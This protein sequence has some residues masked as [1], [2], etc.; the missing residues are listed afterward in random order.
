MKRAVIV[1]AK[2]A[3]PGKVKTRLAVDLGDELAS[4]YYRAFARDVLE[5]VESYTQS[6]ETCLPYLAWSGSKQGELV[7]HAQELGFSVIDQG[8]GGLGAR[9]ESVTKRLREDHFDR[10]LVIGTD[11][12][13]LMPEHLKEAFESLERHDLVFGPSF[14]G[15]Y[16]LVGIDL[17]SAFGARIEEAIFRDITWSTPGVLTE[18]LAAVRRVGLLCDLLGFWYDIDTYEDLNIMWTH[19]KFL[20]G[21]GFQGGRNS[22]HFL[23]EGLTRSDEIQLDTQDST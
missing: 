2:E 20:R 5:M 6:E 22:L 9:M 13:T 11:S 3:I 19:L 8:T 14:D 16:Y 7:E 10:L 15:G 1:F 18:S 17:R 21:K 23:P 12:P 4:Q